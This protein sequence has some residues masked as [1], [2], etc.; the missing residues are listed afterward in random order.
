MT[1]QLSVVRGGV[2]RPEIVEGRWRIRERLVQVRLRTK[3]AIETVEIILMV[4]RRRR[5]T[6]GWNRQGRG[7]VQFERIAH[8]ERARSAHSHREQRLFGICSRVERA[9]E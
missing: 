6:D 1:F 5:G 8:D 3:H 9:I 7:G 2:H 4:V